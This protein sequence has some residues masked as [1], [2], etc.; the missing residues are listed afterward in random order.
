MGLG[1]GVY[2][3]GIS[4]T[5]EMQ[6]ILQSI[7][8]EAKA[9]ENLSNDLKILFAE[10]IDAHG[11]ATQLSISKCSNNSLKEQ[12]SQVEKSKRTNMRALFHRRPFF[13]SDS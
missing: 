7:N 8:N 6:G 3:F 5:E 9:K 1:V 12:N 4:A 11:I 2:L 13:Q 10:F